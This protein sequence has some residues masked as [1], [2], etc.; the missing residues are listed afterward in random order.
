M[1]DIF[2]NKGL[3]SILHIYWSDKISSA[4]SQANWNAAQIVEVK[5]RCRCR[6]PVRVSHVAIGESSKEFASK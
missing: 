1:L 2:H 3:S 5:R 6:V 4:Y